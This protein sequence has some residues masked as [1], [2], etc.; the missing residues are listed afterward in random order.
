M[1]LGDRIAKRLSEMGISQRNLAMTVGV[2]EVTMSR[3]I[4]DKRIPNALILANICRAL[5]VKADYLLGIE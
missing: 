4:K 2:T 3:Y 5:G 1:T